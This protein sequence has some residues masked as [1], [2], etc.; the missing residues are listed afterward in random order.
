MRSSDRVRSMTSSPRR[1]VVPVS[2]HVRRSGVA[3]EHAG[4]RRDPEH[5]AGRVLRA[6][7]PAVARPV[8]E[9]LH[10]VRDGH[11]RVRRGGRVAQVVDEQGRHDGV[12][13]V[14][15]EDLQAEPPGAGVGRGQRLVLDHRLGPRARG[16]VQRHPD[17]V[18]ARG[19]RPPA[20]QP[21]GEQV[22]GPLL[23]DQA[24]A[25]A[26]LDAGGGEHGVR[27]VLLELPGQAQ[28]RAG[29]APQPGRAP[30]PPGLLDRLDRGGED[31]GGR[32]QPGQHDVVA[33]A[34]EVHADRVDGQGHPHVQRA[35]GVDVVAQR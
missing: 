33:G 11:G 22:V 27:V 35:V 17:A 29:V 5:R 8:D 12:R 6:P 26:V 10:R 15:L 19:H 3:L 32:G 24:V 16:D 34:D 18:L 31:V 2:R 1:L 14:R 20:L 13:R 9:Q 4:D 7:Q 23:A 25:D 21:L 30:A 28:R